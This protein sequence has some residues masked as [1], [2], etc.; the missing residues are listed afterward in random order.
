M[1]PWL[2]TLVTSIAHQRIISYSGIIQLSNTFEVVHILS[3]YLHSLGKV[4]RG[5][6][7]RRKERVEKGLFPTGV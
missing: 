6:G 4:N 7:K 3:E 5:K 2:N 1:L